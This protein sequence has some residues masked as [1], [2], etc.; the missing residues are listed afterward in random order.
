MRL[1]HHKTQVNCNEV[2]IKQHI[3][4]YTTSHKNKQRSLEKA[5]VERNRDAG[6]Y[7]GTLR[8]L[9]RNSKREPKVFEEIILVISRSFC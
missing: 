4:M 3:D 1:Q 2:Q 5:F 9:K 8:N 6:T 7:K